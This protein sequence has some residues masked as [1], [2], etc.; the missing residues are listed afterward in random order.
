M[1]WLVWDLID[2]KRCSLCRKRLVLRHL[3]G[4]NA[5]ILMAHRYTGWRRWE[6]VYNTKLEDVPG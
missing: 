1:S 6:R 3:I 4:P 5:D 2:G